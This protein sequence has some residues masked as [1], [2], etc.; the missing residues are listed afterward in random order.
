M[1]RGGYDGGPEVRWSGADA[2]APEVVLLHGHGCDVDAVQ[3]LAVALPARARLAAVRGPL[4]APGGGRAWFEA[5]RPGEPHGPSLAR[6][7]AWLAAWLGTLPRRSARPIVVGHS[8]GGAT[9]AALALRHPDLVGGLGLVH[10]SVPRTDVTVAGRLAGLPTLVVHGAR[11][12]TLS[13]EVLDRTWRYLHD[14]SGAD[15]VG[16]RHD[17]DHD[18]TPGVARTVGDWLRTL[19]PGGAAPDATPPS[20]EPRRS[21]GPVHGAPG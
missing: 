7:V 17:G 10:A 20:P 21:H 12:R 11:D 8:A 13:T 5:T 2:G 6:T 3:D 15:V 14:R 16:V 19:V 9:A 18:L 4:P 1:G